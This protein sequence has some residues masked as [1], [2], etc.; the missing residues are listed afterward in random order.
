MWKLLSWEPD[1]L[2][3]SYCHTGVF[4]KSGGGV[5]PQAPK[6]ET[7]FQK[8]EQPE[9][10]CAFTLKIKLFPLEVFVWIIFLK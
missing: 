5:L 1:F 3:R 6:G 7:K 4:K 2:A 10:F 8:Q 9:E